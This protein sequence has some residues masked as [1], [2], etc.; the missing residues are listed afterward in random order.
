M[1]S[2]STKKTCEIK[3]VN[4]RLIPLNSRPNETKVLVNNGKYIFHFPEFSKRIAL[5]GTSK[6]VQQDI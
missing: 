2:E 4:D 5:S 3:C 6:V 1:I